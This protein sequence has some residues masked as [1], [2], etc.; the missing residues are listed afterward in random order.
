MATDEAK[1]I[2]VGEIEVEYQEWG[3]GERPFVLVHGFT[4]SRDDWR[5]VA[6]VL[7]RARRVVAPDLRGHGGSTNLGRADAYSFDLLA[8]DL[9]GFLN[10]MGIER[11][12][13]LGHS[14]GGSVAMR[15]TLSAPERVASLVLMDTSAGAFHGTRREV[16]EL[17]G[18]VAREHGMGRLFELAR[19]MWKDSL[20]PSVM[21]LQKTMG[22]DTYFA[23]IQQKFEAMDPEA[24]RTLG[25]ALSEQSD[26]LERVPDIR[27]PTLVVVGE[28]DLPLLDAAQ[29]LA[30]ALPD[31]THAVIPNAAHSPQLEHSDAWLATL[32]AH[33][34]RIDA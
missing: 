34:E 25:L 20:P 30:A 24:F 15:A 17:G 7:A 3:R 5:E 32:E 13:L 2:R 22:V 23:R 28:E 10:A 19:K 29:E 4:G 18:R 21:K 14:M 1:R 26:L 8:Q 6:P 12:D 11:C 16:Y 31:T 33:F 27:C 9:V